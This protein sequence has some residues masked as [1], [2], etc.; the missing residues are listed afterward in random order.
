MCIH[1]G[2]IPHTQANIPSHPNECSIT[3]QRNTH[4]TVTNNESKCN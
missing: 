2:S 3:S 4:H 1:R